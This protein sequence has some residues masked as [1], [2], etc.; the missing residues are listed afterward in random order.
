MD[1]DGGNVRKVVGGPDQEWNATWSPNGRHLA[2]ERSND[3]TFTSI[4]TIRSDGTD[5]KKLTGRRHIFASNSS[6]S[7]DGRRILFQAQ[8]S[9]E[10][11]I[12]IFVMRRD[13]TNKKS[14]IAAS[15]DQQG[16]SWSPNDQ[17]IAFTNIWRVA[18][19]RPDGS[20]VVDLFEHDFADYVVDW[21]RAV[22][23]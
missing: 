3:S 21:G 12:D 18:R 22:R 10:R 15:G 23:Y 7:H 14:L 16:P 13:G 2:L 19:A 8:R 5:L 20:G 11:G 17:G 4:F 6:W 1:A 9:E